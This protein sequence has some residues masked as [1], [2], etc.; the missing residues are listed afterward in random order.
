MK[1]LDMT[2]PEKKEEENMKD[3]DDKANKAVAVGK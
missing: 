3:K 2:T 1:A